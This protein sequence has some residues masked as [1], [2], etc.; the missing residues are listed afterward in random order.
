MRSVRRTLWW[1]AVIMLVGCSGPTFDRLSRFFFDVPQ[2]G[3]FGDDSAMPPEAIVADDVAAAFGEGLPGGAANTTEG[4]ASR[5][6]QSDGPAFSPA[7]HTGSV[8]QPVAERNCAVCH[9]PDR[10][11][12]VRTDLAA[13]CSNCHPRYF[14]A[15]VGHPPVKRAR[16]LKCHEMHRSPHAALLTLPPFDTCMECHD[17]PEELSPAAHTRPD[18]QRCTLCHDAHFGRGFRIK[19]DAPWR[20]E[21]QNLAESDEE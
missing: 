13:A 9:D 18:V 17:P 21:D 6:T 3:R 4:R 14:S 12:H 10:Q 19:P 7:T 15:E 11:M 8:H 20:A 2:S 16:C 1:F 5:P